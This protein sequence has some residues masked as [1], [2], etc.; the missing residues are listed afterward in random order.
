MQNWVGQI[1]ESIKPKGSHVF[2]CL[3]LVSGVYLVTH[4]EIISIVVGIGLIVFA[5]MGWAISHRNVDLEGGEPFKI[6]SDSDGN[7]KVSMDPRLLLNSSEMRSIVLKILEGSKNRETLP[8]PDGR[9]GDN[10][11]IIKNDEESK[12]HIEEI[13]QQAQAISQ[14]CAIDT[15][16]NE[17][18]PVPTEA[19][20]K[21]PE[22][23][24]E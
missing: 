17:T 2:L 7:T 16:G 6:E 3:L 13:N 8:L 23:N 15:I 19:G 21:Q 14:K 10:K 5:V 11:E 1:S 20:I 4:G 12:R 22:K 18:H 9:I 24:H